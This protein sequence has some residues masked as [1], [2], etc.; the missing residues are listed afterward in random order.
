MSGILGGLTVACIYNMTV[1]ATVNKTMAV[2]EIQ[3]QPSFL[4]AT[5]FNMSK[6]LLPPG[7]LSAEYVQVIFLR[8]ILSM[9]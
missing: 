6:Q 7:G 3:T 1:I 2:G 4:L 5:F 9:S 8:M